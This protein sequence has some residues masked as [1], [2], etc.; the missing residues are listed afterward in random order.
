MSVQQSDFL[1]R[2]GIKVTVVGAITNVSLALIKFT[3][4]YFGGS[5]ALIADAMDSASDLISDVIVMVS[6]RIS[7]KPRD[8]DHPY[9]HGRA[10]TIGAIAI[11][12]I[13]MAV[14][15]EYILHAVKIIRSGVEGSPTGLA[16]CGAVVSICIKEACYRYTISVGKALGSQVIIAN[17]RHH[18]SDELSSVVA[19][20]GVIGAMAGY[21]ILDP[22][23]AIVLAFVVIKAGFQIIWGGTQE[24]MDA[25]VPRESL[26]EIEET[27]LKSPEVVSFHDL[28]TRKIGRETLVDVHIQ[29]HPYI[30]VSEGHNIAEN[31]RGELIS[32][33]KNMG[34]VMVHIDA[35][36]DGPGIHYSFTRSQLE[37]KVRESMEKIQPLGKHFD[38]QV[39]YLFGKAFLEIYIELPTEMAIKEGKEI[40]RKIKNDLIHLE[41]VQDVKVRL[42]LLE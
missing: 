3:A 26:R 14:G 22:M 13:L 25:S 5:S 41:E 20:A 7:S 24:M 2:T 31:V 1:H 9:G 32:H 33:M 38:M 35:E 18:R 30:S 4:G 8:A 37:Q 19:M 11:G 23:A 15:V 34:E 17:A 16:L 21:K 29:V 42:N 27:I 36:D 10:E 12:L 39:H 40:A 28:K 6:L